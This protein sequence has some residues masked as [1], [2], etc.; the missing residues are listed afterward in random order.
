[1]GKGKPIEEE[2]K[3]RMEEEGN[4][5]MEEEGKWGMEEEQKQGDGGRRATGRWR[6]VGD[7]H[8]AVSHCSIV[9]YANLL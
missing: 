7:C 9:V 3:Q 8:S 5:G 6:N 4:Q 1:M 2:G